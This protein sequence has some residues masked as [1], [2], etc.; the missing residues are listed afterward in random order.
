[1]I[2]L[3]NVTFFV[4]KTENYHIQKPDHNQRSTTFVSILFVSSPVSSTTTT[5]PSHF[6]LCYF[7]EKLTAV[8]PNRKLLIMPSYYDIDAILAEEELVPCTPCFDFAF[9]AWLDPNQYN[10]TSET[11]KRF[12]DGDNGSKRSSSS[13]TLSEG[14]KIHMP[15][16]AI[17]K[18]SSLS[19]VRIGIPRHF[20]RK[21]REKFM[22]DPV[23][24]PIRVTND[25]YFFS[26]AIL[27]QLI[28]RCNTKVQTD[29]RKANRSN[30]TG[31]MQNL[32][33]RNQ[34]A[35]AVQALYN[36]SLDMRNDMLLLFSGSRL[37]CTLDWT[38]FTSMEDDVSQQSFRLT[39][40]ERQL[41]VAGAAASKALYEWKNFRGGC[42]Q[43]TSLAHNPRSVRTEKYEA[44]KSMAKRVKV[45]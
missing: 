24:A 22:A 23:H 10:A 39:E 44:S 4:W 1:M 16:W 42:S 31:R 37:R 8:A 27:V 20:S 34:H 9:L 36:E 11:R 41:F 33:R 32:Q 25:Q 12:R 3:R 18:W 15:L 38:M 29:L 6:E 45:H 26:A 5:T 2:R 14:N 43:V 40:M 21:A 7:L 30:G 19:F 17:E 28:D 35:Q 13:S